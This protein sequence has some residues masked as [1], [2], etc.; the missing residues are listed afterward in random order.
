[1]QSFV[2]A[3]PSDPSVENATFLYEANLVNVFD[4]GMP[5]SLHQVLGPFG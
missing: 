3:Q 1:M 2:F 4:K 5:E